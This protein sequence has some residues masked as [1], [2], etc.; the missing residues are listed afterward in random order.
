MRAD[1]RVKAVAIDG[2]TALNAYVPP[3]ERRGLVLIDP[4]F[5]QAD[6]FERL[7]AGAC[8]G[9]PQVADRHLHALVSD[10]GCACDG[11]ICPPARRLRHCR[12]FCAPNSSV[13]A[14]AIP[15]ARAAAG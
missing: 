4:P 2:Y 5:E 6:E 11:G 14:R 13:A 10:Q 9:P 7:G 12:A 1:D 3:K 15:A 8:R